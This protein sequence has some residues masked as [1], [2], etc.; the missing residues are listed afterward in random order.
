[1]KGHGAP[2]NLLGGRRLY[3]DIPR[4]AVVTAAYNAASFIAATIESVLAQR[5]RD[6]EYV[7]IDDNSTDATGAIAESFASSDSRLRILKSAM[8]RGPGAARNLGMSATTAPL[9]AF[10]D[11]DDCWEP[12][13]LSAMLAE[14]R[15]QAPGCVGVFCHSRVIGANGQPT[16]TTQHAAAGPYY[17]YDFFRHIFPPGNGSALLMHRRYLEESGGFGDLRSLED[18]ELILRIL[19][20]S[21]E[22]HIVAL[23]RTL[24]RYRERAQGLSRDGGLIE[25]GWR[26][27]IE[28][29][30]E[31]LPKQRRWVIFYNFARFYGPR[32]PDTHD[33]GT[34]LM[35]RALAVRAPMEA[36]P[37]LG[38]MTLIAAIGWRRYLAV[39]RFA[40]RCIAIARTTGSAA[41]H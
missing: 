35:R 22:R 2:P 40:K 29:F 32:A 25:H 38:E 13:F 41:A 33:F 7:I 23:P 10:I 24:V 16:G 36:L 17:F 4:I 15:R 19:H 26:I 27:G 34:R 5:F 18:L 30:V 12:D 39:R 37:L 8:N 11:S 21:S 28:R 6:F 31:C 20:L 1:M 14:L 3:V 9:I